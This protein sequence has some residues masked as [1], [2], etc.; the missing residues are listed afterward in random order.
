MWL[1]GG[2]LWPRAGLFLILYWAWG[3]ASI[4]LSAPAPD[5]VP[6]NTGISTL[7]GIGASS[8]PWYGVDANVIIFERIRRNFE[9]AR[10]PAS[11]ETGFKRLCIIMDSNITTII[12]A[13]VLYILGTACKGLCVTL[14][15][16]ILSFITAVSSQKRLQEI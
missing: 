4:A 13:A 15:L 1:L 12:V 2:V 10:P 7:P 6:A 3:F 11:I 8:F 14:G 9:K 16:V 5:P